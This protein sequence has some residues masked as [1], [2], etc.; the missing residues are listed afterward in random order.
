MPY[1]N[2][3]DPERGPSLCLTPQVPGNRSS[4]RSSKL[5]SIA[6]PEEEGREIEYLITSIPH[7]EQ[8]YAVLYARFAR[9]FP[10]IA[11]KLS[12]PQ[13]VQDISRQPSRTPFSSS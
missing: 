9:R 3:N 2:W 13:F 6:A 7:H 11:M 8:A 4:S 12:K 5:K 1:N 10:D